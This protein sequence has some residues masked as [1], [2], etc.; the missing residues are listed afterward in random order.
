MPEPKGNRSAKGASQGGRKEPASE[1]VPANPLSGRQA[2]IQVALL[3][4]IPLLLLLLAKVLLR[5][6]FPSLGY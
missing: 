3:I 6:F 1:L 4:G 5:Q 2:L